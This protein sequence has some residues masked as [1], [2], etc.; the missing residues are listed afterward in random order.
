MTSTS[1]PLEEFYLQDSRGYVGTN[2]SWWQEGGNGY[3]TD[4]R[5]AHKYSKD[6]AIRSHNSRSTDIPWSKSYIDTRTHPAV[7]MQYIKREVA[8][9]VPALQGDYLG[10]TLPENISD[11]FYLQ[12]SRD[13][14]GNDVLWRVSEGF[15]VSNDISRARVFS[16]DAVRRIAFGKSDRRILNERISDILWPKA[17]IDAKTR[18]AVDRH[19]V[20]IDEA[21][22][23]TGIVLQK[24]GKVRPDQYRC[25][26]CNRFMSAKQMWSG[27]C[28]NCGADSRP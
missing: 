22:L 21:L 2:I 3:T 11:E 6:E 24:P 12:D 28:P 8:L 4:L 19:H 23:G 25:Y 18:P 9:L 10:D 17:Y 7:D 26:N 13:Y 16:R 5:K 20:K 14:V 1:K 27:E 15:A